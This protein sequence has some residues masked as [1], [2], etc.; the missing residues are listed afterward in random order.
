MIN[1]KKGVNLKKKLVKKQVYT[2]TI[3]KSKLIKNNK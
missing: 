1:L 3:P 2:C